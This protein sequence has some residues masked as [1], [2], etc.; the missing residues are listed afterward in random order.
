MMNLKQ[1]TGLVAGL[2]I[3]ATSAHAAEG[4]YAGGSLGRASTDYTASNQNLSPGSTKDDSGLGWSGL[5]GYQ[6]NRNFALQADFI[7]YNDSKIKDVKGING[8]DVK[9]EQAAGDVVGKLIFPF[10]NGF[11]IFATGGVAYVKLDE[12]PNSTAKA[13]G[14][15]SDDKDGVRPTYGLGVGYDF[16]SGWSA[17]ASWSQIPSGGSIEQSNY[18]GLGLNFH[19]S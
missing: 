11:N 16:Y 17:I 3:V 15:N 19:F 13:I 8:A 10:G 14:I 18:F 4:I 5:L 6:M 1:I 7:Q 9:Y 12:K 2:F